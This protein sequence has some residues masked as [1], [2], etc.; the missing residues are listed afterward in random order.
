M[1]KSD[2]QCQVV[3]LWRKGT[4]SV[5]EIAAKLRRSQPTI[6][7]LL[8]RALE[9]GDVSNRPRRGRPPVSSE[10]DDQRLLEIVRVHWDKPLAWIRRQWGVKCSSR[11]LRNRLR[12]KY[13]WPRG[14]AMR[15]TPI[16]ESHRQP[17]VEW[18]ENHLQWSVSDWSKVLWCDEKTWL[19]TNRGRVWIFRPA[20]EHKNPKF[21]IRERTIP[22]SIR[23]W[24]CFG[25]GRRGAFT[26]FDGSMTA[27]KYLDV[28][29]NH[30]VPTARRLFC[31]W[32][33]LQDDGDGPGRLGLEESHAAP[34]LAL[35]GQLSRSLFD[36]ECLEHLA[37]TSSEPLP[38]DDRRDAAL[39]PGRVG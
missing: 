25:N 11:T 16:Q 6:S 7:R 17:R 13:S 5:S 20:G 30:A 14:V 28:L 10:S 21:Q 2:L 34:Q 18:A 37:P 8:H 38:T 35:A 12:T 24:A 3:R 31:R 4:L 32:W 33:W 9:C 22:G 23:T 27:D 15:R 26:F 1:V 36:R 39:Y 29:R 19:L